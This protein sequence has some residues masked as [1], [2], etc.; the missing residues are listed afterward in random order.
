MEDND[1]MND[2]S[3]PVKEGYITARDGARLYYREQGEGRPLIL[4]HGWIC[5]SKFWNKNVPELSRF[6]RV[7]TPD[8]RGHGN[9]SKIL[10]GHTVEEYARDVRDIIEQLN[11]K[12][13]IL[14]GWSLAGPVSLV[15]WKLFKNDSRLSGIGIVDSAIAPFS[16]YPWNSH[17]LRDFNTE[18]L[19][20]VINSYISDLELHAQS[21]ARRIFHN[22]DLSESELSWIVSEV[23]KTP[24]WIGIAI[25]S[26]FV[27][28]D[29]VDILPTLTVPA[30][31]FAS[32]ST[33]YKN[34]VFMGQSIASLIPRSFFHPVENA[35]HILFYEKPETFNKLLKEF[36]DGL[37]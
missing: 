24:P 36:I 21:F 18:G 26:D 27:L 37:N 15:Y 20:K 17:T 4:L 2:K 11:L 13:S 32:D 34:G 7:I 35:G 28:N 25:Y 9:S 23:L 33:T 16:S 6:Y 14:V 19:S 3:F 22:S 30:V 5:S 1:N 12:D 31:V 10:A 29:C 8:F